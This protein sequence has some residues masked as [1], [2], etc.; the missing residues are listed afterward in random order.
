MLA[1]AIARCETDTAPPSPGLATVQRTSGR[2][3]SSGRGQISKANSS[4]VSL[5]VSRYPS[6]R[7]V[8][9]MSPVDKVTCSS[10][11]DFRL[12]EREARWGG[13]EIAYKRLI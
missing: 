11:V 10:S 8:F 3:S 12:A 13:P 2:L 6:T 7:G 1:V 9:L 4:P 5:A